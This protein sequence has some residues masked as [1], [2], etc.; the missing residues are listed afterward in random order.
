MQPNFGRAYELRALTLNHL[1]N[2]VLQNSSVIS[3]IDMVSL[4]LSFGF[5]ESQRLGPVGCLGRLELFPGV[6]CKLVQLEI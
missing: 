2:I 5:F 3:G 1:L 6:S 4:G